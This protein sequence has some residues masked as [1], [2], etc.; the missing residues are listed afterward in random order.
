LPQSFPGSVAPNSP[1]PFSAMVKNDSK[2]QW[3]LEETISVASRSISNAHE[4]GIPYFKALSFLT[5]LVYYLSW[6]EP[7]PKSLV[8]RLMH[9]TVSTF[10]DLKD[11]ALYLLY[12]SS[13]QVLL[14]Y[15]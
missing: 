15:T 2:S 8:A 6:I 5:V 1:F 3:P 14:S 11:P 9:I 13:S 7:P 10:L 12:F 4:S